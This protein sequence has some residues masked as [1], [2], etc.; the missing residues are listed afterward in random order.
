LSYAGR[1]VIF[2]GDIEMNSEA[3]LIN[4]YGNKIK[5]D[6]LLV[7]HHG[8]RYSSSKPFLEMVSPEVCI[9]SSRGGNRFGFPHVETLDRLNS[10]RAKI[11]RID[12]GGAV[13]VKIGEGIFSA[14]YCLD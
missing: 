8:S 6:I 3:I 14:G 13:E 9:I 12:Q 11:F 2:P 5:S 1:S 10:I 4:K 7:P